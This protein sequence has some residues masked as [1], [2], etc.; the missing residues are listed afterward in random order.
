[1]GGNLYTDAPSF[2]FHGFQ[3]FAQV[4][5]AQLRVHGGATFVE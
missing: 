1:M 5:V 3:E 4:F 2:A